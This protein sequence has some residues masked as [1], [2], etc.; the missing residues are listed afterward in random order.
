MVRRP[1]TKKDPSRTALRQTALAAARAAGRILTAGSRQEIKVR[2]KGAIDLVTDLD[3]QSEDRIVRTIRKRYPDHRLIAE[4]GHLLEGSSDYRWI[5]DPLDGTTNYAHGFPFYCISIALEHEGEM[6]LG[7]V[8]DPVRPELFVAEKGR[9]AT[10]NG[11]PI[12]VSSKGSMAESL[13][14]TGFA[15][16][17]R[18]SQENNID[19]FVRFSHLSQGIRRTGSAALDLCYVAC[20]RFDGFWELKL[21]PW[22]VAAG[23][24]IVREAGG[25]VSSFSGGPFR[26][27]AKE[28]LATNGKIHAEMV[29][30]FPRTGK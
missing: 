27:H 20:G 9:G 28:I 7:V 17:V 16:D 14:V 15:Y 26:I 29:A 22:D 10:L 4:E 2:Y 24:L 30:A 12:R 13:L 8:Y 6:L 1:S 18:V 5:I 21:N 25:E 19:H 23:S 11:R 3:R